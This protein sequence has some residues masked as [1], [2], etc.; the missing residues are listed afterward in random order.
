MLPLKSI[1]NMV[2]GDGVV[3]EL[4]VGCRF[5][6]HY[7][8][9][10]RSVAIMKHTTE[11]YGAAAAVHPAMAVRSVLLGLLIAVGVVTSVPAIARANVSIVVNVPPPEQRVEV[12]PESRAGYVWA[13]GY[14][15][16]TGNHHT[17]HK[18]HWNRERRGYQW[19]PDHWE[20]RDGQHH[21]EPGR[22][23]RQQERQQN[24]PQNRR[25]DG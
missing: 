2:A 17:W 15:G 22:W 7:L 9:R 12:V 3:T 16:W 8:L 14:W 19:S 1:S 6:S 18:G 13:P 4:I 25:T 24:Q 21:F 11:R 23:Q 10:A 5:D 20:Q